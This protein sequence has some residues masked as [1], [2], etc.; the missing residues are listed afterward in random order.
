MEEIDIW[1]EG[2]FNPTDIIENRIK[3][4]DSDNIQ[5]KIGLY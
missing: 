4:E 3:K 5:K 2:P 1:W